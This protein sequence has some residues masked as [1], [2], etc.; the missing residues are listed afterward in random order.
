V[1]SIIA[2]AAVLPGA[3]T[4]DPR[5]NG[6][7]GVD[8]AVLRGTRIECTIGNNKS[9]GEHQ[10]GY[11]GIFALRARGSAHSAFVSLYAGV[12]L[13][14]YFGTAPRN[15]NGTTLFEPRHAPMEVKRIADR[16]VELHQ[17]PTPVWRVESWTRFEV[18]NPHYVD[19]T[20]RCQPRDNTF[21]DG[22]MGVFWA[23][24]MNA[25]EDKSIYFLGPE[26]TLDH[27]KW[28]QLCTQH[29]D[30]CSTVRRVDDTTN[31]AFAEAPSMLWNQLSPLRFSKPFFYGRVGNMVLIYI[32]EDSPYL[33]FTHSPSGGGPTADGT[34]TCPAWD[35]QLVV[36][37]VQVD[38][39]YGL[40]LRVVYKRWVSRADV[41]DEVRRYNAAK[42]DG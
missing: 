27:P 17:P 9:A 29:H 16:A 37:N 5:G 36:P 40:R 13:E 12:N 26:S 31:T 25:P 7:E 19:V 21:H 6:V 34:D 41:L 22:V 3:L 30:H 24:Y 8:F 32:F 14:H 18:K 11:N 20:Y 42:T 38:T 10:A 4:D 35:F 2:A 33:R 23:S 39:E 15:A 1:L 28:L